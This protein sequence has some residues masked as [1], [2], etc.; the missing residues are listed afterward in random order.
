MSVLDKDDER[1]LRWEERT[2][3]PLAAG[4]GVFLLTLVVPLYLPDVPSPWG[5]LLTAVGLLTW[6]GFAVDYGVRLVLAGRRRH[7]VATHPLE[8]LVVLAPLLQPLASLRLVAVAR[9]ALVAGHTTR[10]SRSAARGRLTATAGA[11]TAVLMVVS[12]GLV[13][14]AERGAPDANITTAGDAVWWSLATVTTVGYGDHFPVTGAGRAVAT[15]LMLVGIALLGTVSASIA[16][17]FVDTG[18]RDQTSAAVDDDV[19]VTEDVAVR[20]RE[21]ERTIT[22]LR[23]QLTASGPTG[24]G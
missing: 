20:L 7:F 5:G 10:A 14:Q 6:A 4:A 21:L 18:D 23:D 13:L 3:V 24:T 22:A 11:V 2:R 1:R 9:A 12:G 16:A 8:L 19:A 15:V 17:F